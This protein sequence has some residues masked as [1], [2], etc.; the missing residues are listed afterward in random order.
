MTTPREPTE[1][2]VATREEVDALRRE[3]AELKAERAAADS[4]RPGPLMTNVLAGFIVAGGLAIITVASYLLR[5]NIPL[6]AWIAIS[7]ATTVLTVLAGSF[8]RRRLGPPSREK[9][10]L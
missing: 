6:V 5:T 10:P 4:R 2:P 1:P 3:L 8:A 7:A 9:L